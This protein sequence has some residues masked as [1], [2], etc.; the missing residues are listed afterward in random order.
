MI[1]YDRIGDV[2]RVIKSP[3]QGL[4]FDIS[5]ENLQSNSYIGTL[6]CILANLSDGFD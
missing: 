4:L 6:V 3:D 5:I 1:L 2:F